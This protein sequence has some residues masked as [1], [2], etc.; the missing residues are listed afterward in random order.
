MFSSSHS[1]LWLWRSCWNSRRDF[2]KI[3]FESYLPCCFYICLQLVGDAEKHVVCSNVGTCHL[4]TLPCSSIG[5]MYRGEERDCN[6]VAHKCPCWATPSAGYSPMQRSW[7][8]LKGAAGL[9]HFAF[10]HR[11]WPASVLRRDVQYTERANSVQWQFLGF[12]PV[13]TVC[14]ASQEERQTSTS[15]QHQEQ[16]SAHFRGLAHEPRIGKTRSSLENTQPRVT[17]WP[18]TKGEVKLIV[19]S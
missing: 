2:L 17:T 4:F 5:K 3:Y 15:P 19:P 12:C 11:A 16:T 9:W 13:Q 10:N 14:T 8:L 18:F 1:H 7:H 6:S